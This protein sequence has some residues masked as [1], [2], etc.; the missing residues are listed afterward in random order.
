LP[1]IHP[2]AKLLLDL[3]NISSQKNDPLPIHNRKALEDRRKSLRARLTAAEATLWN[4]LK[5]KKLEGRKF[6]RQHSVGKYILDFYCP[7]E[8]LSIELDGEH[9]FTA[10]GLIYDEERTKYLHSVKIRNQVRK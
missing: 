7:S 4:L 1:I 2:L 10:E 9:H 8:R 6:R 5:G 3:K